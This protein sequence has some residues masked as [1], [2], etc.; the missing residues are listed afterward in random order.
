MTNGGERGDKDDIH[1][2]V[3]QHIACYGVPSC[4]LQLL[5]FGWLQEE[6]AESDESGSGSERSRLSPTHAC[7]GLSLTA[8]QGKPD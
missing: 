5:W 8:R 3:M 1:L 2:I 6:Q 7:W 4:G